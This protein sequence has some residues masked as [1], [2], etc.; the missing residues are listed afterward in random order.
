MGIT[1]ALRIAIP[2]DV[3]K[4]N[5]GSG[6]S[7][8][9]RLVGAGSGSPLCRHGLGVRELLDGAGCT[10]ADAFAFQCPGAKR[11]SQVEDQECVFGTRPLVQ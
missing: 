9:L 7:A 2:L 3:P 5:H 8:R 4:Q 11:T 6:P 1:N 10:T